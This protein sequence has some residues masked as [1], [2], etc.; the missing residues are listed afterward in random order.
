MHY[1]YFKMHSSKVNISSYVGLVWSDKISPRDIK[2]P[3]FKELEGSSI[4]SHTGLQKPEW[5]RIKN[6]K[7]NIYPPFGKETANSSNLPVHY[8]SLMYY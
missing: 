5:T 4:S 6:C 7:W 2:S 3:G 8:N 1:N